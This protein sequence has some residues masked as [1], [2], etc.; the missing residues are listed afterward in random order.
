MIPNLIGNKP[1]WKL[2]KEELKRIGREDILSNRRFSR[3]Y[4][5]HS[6]NRCFYYKFLC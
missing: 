3:Y 6:R 2:L 4:D 5:L 1:D